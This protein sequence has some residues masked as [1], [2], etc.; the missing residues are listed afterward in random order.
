MRQVGKRF[1]M[2]P[3]LYKMWTF[4]TTWPVDGAGWT[5]NAAGFRFTS[6]LSLHYSL[7][8][9]VSDLFLVITVVTSIINQHAQ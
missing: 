2:K 4:K 3:Q 1:N 5:G 9:L 8:E 6:I 7:S